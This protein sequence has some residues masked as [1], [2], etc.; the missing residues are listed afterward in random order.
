MND[1]LNTYLSQVRK[2]FPT[3]EDF[4]KGSEDFDREERD[5]KL[6]LVELYR[7]KVA[8]SLAHFPSDIDSQIK[9]GEQIS[10]LFTVP[11]KGSGKRPQNLVGYRYFEPLRFKG[12]ENAAWATLVKDLVCEDIDLA[13]RVDAFVAKITPMINRKLRDNKIAINALSRSVVSFFLMLH[14][15]DRHAIVKTRQFKR[16]L[17]AFGYAAMPNEPLSG[18]EYV[19]LQRF[20]FDLKA[21][22]EAQGKHPRD[23]IDIQSFV[24]VGDPTT[25][26]DKKPITASP[27]K[28][29]SQP[30]DTRRRALNTILYGPPGTG[31][32]YNTPELALKI[33]DGNQF[34]KETTR[35][36]FRELLDRGDIG[37]VTFHQSFSYED[38][39]EGIRPETVDNKV[40]TYPVRNGIFR[41]LCERAEEDD[42]RNYVLIIDEINRANLSRVLGELI[43][44]L[45]TD[46]RLGA[47][48]ELRLSLPYSGEKFGVPANLY[49]I[50]TM[51]TADRS[52]ALLDTALRRRFEFEE[53]MPRPELLEDCKIDPGDGTDSIALDQLLIGLNSRLEVLYDRDHTIGHA[54]FMGVDSMEELDAVFRHKII[55][56]LQEY[57]YEDW[58]KVELVLEDVDRPDFLTKDTVDAS[59]FTATSLPQGLESRQIYRVNPEQF[60]AEAYR[61][62]CRRKA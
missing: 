11:L 19:R 43:T 18:E 59:I 52:I 35:Q 45:E 13:A 48:N 26:A 21:A 20:M 33:V 15:R 25:Y 51:N 39:V 46:K 60:P 57:F 41:R 36:R 12:E 42:D 62:I 7:N 8:N 17:K 24:W 22:L 2:H 28:E 32:T 27:P 61:R 16:A 5:Y 4:G 37:F 38:F 6:E 29:Q 55:P 10:S 47:P 40:V 44:L 9:I 31:K 50:G 3:F 1:A 58:Y 49:I 56:L 30:S 23:L 54:Y 34:D 14:D 53:M